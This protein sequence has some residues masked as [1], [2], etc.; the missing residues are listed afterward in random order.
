MDGVTSLGGVT[1]APDADHYIYG[2]P[3][4]LSELFVVDGLK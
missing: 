1:F 4:L 3:R 2:Y